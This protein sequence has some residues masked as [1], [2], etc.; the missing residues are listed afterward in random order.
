E[1][2]VDA[3]IAVELQSPA[4]PLGQLLDAGAQ[5]RGELLGRP[6]GDAA[7]LL[8][9]GVMFDLLRGDAAG[10]LRVSAELQLPYRQTAQALVAEHAD[11]K[12]AALDILLGDGVGADLLVDE[13]H[14]LGQLLLA[15]HQGGLGDPARRVFA[16]ALDDEREAKARRAA[17]LAADREDGEGRDGDAVVVHELLRQRLAAG[18]HEAARV[19]AGVGNPHQLEIAGDVLVVR[20]LAVKLLEKIEDSMRLPVLDLVA[21]RLQFVLHAEGLNVV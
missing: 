5:F 13:G 11:I 10:T 19:A 7:A 14:A 21:D 2:K 18:Q 20:G 16:D 8:I 6:G 12:L 4:D 9:L 17:D 1:A 3:G 15:I